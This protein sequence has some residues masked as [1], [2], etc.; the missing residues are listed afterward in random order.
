[1]IWQHLFTG[2]DGETYDLGRILWAVAAVGFV[3][4]AAIAVL[5]GKDFNPQDYGIGAGSLLGGGGAGIG[6]KSKTEPD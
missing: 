3:V 4:F 6:L 2:K 1:M 5:H